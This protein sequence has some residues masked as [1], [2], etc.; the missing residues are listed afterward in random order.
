[1]RS[2]A[3]PIK[4]VAARATASAVISWRAP[5]VFSARRSSPEAL[6]V[7]LAAVSTMASIPAPARPRE[8]TGL[9][10][11]RRPS[12]IHL[13]GGRRVLVAL[14]EDARARLLQRPAASPPAP[15]EVVEHGSAEHS[16]L[17]RESQQHHESRRDQFCARYGLTRDV[18]EA[19]WDSVGRQLASVAAQLDSLVD[20]SAA[21]KEN[22][23]KFGYDARLRAYGGDGA[24][25]D[26]EAG[27]WRKSPS[28]TRPSHPSP[29]QTEEG[30]S[31]GATATDDWRDG[32]EHSETVELFKVP[33][34]KQ[35]FHRGLLW[36]SSRHSK[37]MP[38][39]LFFDLLFVGIIA[40]NGDHVSEDPTGRELIRFVVTFLM[41]WKIWA[42]VTQLVDWFETGDVLSQF[43]LLFLFSC[44]LG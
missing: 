34:V 1:M 9:Y 39:E 17:L 22:F 43:A 31:E 19:E 16:S 12:E 14:P 35:Y 20:H 24:E 21:L 41:S 25:H 32:R 18:L 29:S 40:V 27:R 26:G 8:S 5:G 33:I 36:R 30:E 44:L 23:T 38:F 11:R 10:A 13:P 6:D 7:D 4:H 15:V 42:D 37:V 28:S 2:S 3:R